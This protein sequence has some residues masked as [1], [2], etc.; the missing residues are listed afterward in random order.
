[1]QYQWSSYQSNALG[2]TSSI[3]TPHDEYLALSK[4]KE[5]R[6]TRYRELFSSDIAVKT[7]KELA[8]SLNKGLI[9]GSEKF[10]DEIEFNLKRRVKPGKVGRKPKEMLL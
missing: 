1:M 10:K 8:D 5:E 9:F 3:I 4:N 7:Q 6:H 2:R